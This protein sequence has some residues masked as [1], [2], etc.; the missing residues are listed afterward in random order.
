MIFHELTIRSRDN[1]VN[2]FNVCSHHTSIYILIVSLKKEKC[3]NCLK[4]EFV[5]L[6]KYQTSDKESIDNN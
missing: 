5:M 1:I 3:L 2:K 4:V 6:K